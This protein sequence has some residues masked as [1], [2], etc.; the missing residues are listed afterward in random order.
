MLFIYRGKCVVNC[1]FDIPETFKYFHKLS[2]FVMK[3]TE[4]TFFWSIF[5]VGVGG[6]LV[7]PPQISK[8]LTMAW[9]LGPFPHKNSLL[10]R[11]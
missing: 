10:L 4:L 11:S 8:I 9:K 7:T 1:N 2:E 6:A 3:L 5:A